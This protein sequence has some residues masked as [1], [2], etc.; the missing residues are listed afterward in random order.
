MSDVLDRFE[1]AFIVSLWVGIAGLLLAE[2]VRRAW[3]NFFWEE[4]DG[5]FVRKRRPIKDLLRRR[6]KNVDTG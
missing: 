1:V 5:K 3:V 2:P 6:T 4:K